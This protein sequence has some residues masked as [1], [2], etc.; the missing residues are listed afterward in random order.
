MGSQD[1]ATSCSRALLA[2]PTWASTFF[3]ISSVSQ[4]PPTRLLM[5]L[6]VMLPVLALLNWM[7]PS[8][9]SGAVVISPL[10]VMTSPSLLQRI[11]QELLLPE[12]FMSVISQ[13]L[14]E[15]LRG[16][17]SLPLPIHTLCVMPGIDMPCI[18]ILLVI[19][20]YSPG[21][22]S[23]NV[24]NKARTRTRLAAACLR[25][26]TPSMCIGRNCRPPARLNKG[27]T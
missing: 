6:I 11:F 1:F 7:V 27:R 13:S 14:S 17:F 5:K 23:A 21:A 18:S 15:E 8:V 19:S 12:A 20:Q 16:S 22:A 25:I 3:F 10:P 2:A 26:R 4:A 9:R 24:E